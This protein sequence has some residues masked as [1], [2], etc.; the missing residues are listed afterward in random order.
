[1][2]REQR[3]ILEKAT[4]SG[5]LKQNSKILEFKD[6]L[7]KTAQMFDIQDG[8]FVK[9]N[10]EKIISDVNYENM[11]PDWKSFVEKHK[12]DI[13]KVKMD[14]KMSLFCELVS[15][16]EENNDVW[17]FYLGDLIK[18]SGENDVKI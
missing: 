10:Y 6:R 7:D 5:K 8:D 15:E 17:L 9:L 11:N 18:E 3:R 2:N 14:K 12:N 16:N 4:R 13:L 1:M